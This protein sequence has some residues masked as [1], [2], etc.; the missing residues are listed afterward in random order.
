M[1]SFGLSLLLLKIDIF[2]KTFFTLFLFAL[3][4]RSFACPDFAGLYQPYE[5]FQREII[6]TGCES[7]TI[8]DTFGSIKK[9]RYYPLDGTF[10][11][12]AW[13]S[14]SHA[15]ALDSIEYTLIFDVG[16][17]CAGRYHLTNENNLVDSYRCQS[18][19]EPNPEIAEN[20]Y[21]RINPS[22]DFIAGMKS[23]WL[24]HTL[25]KAEDFY[26]F[27]HQSV[28]GPG[29]LMPDRNQARRN[30]DE[31][32]ALIQPWPRSEPVCE[33]LSNTPGLS[34]LH[35]ANIVRSTGGTA[36]P[37]WPATRERILDAMEH[38]VAVAFTAGSTAGI[39]KMKTRFIQVRNILQQSN[40][41]H[42]IRISYD[43]EYL[44]NKF[45]PM[46]FPAIHHSAIFNENYHPSYRVINS[47][48][49]PTPE[50]H[51]F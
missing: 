32:A 15:W 18:A 19:E 26:K 5:G 8:I 46:G 1:R 38:G 31:E 43:L 7:L 25:M 27:I 51:R 36:S 30:L 2:M 14:H 6:Q 29:H 40:E 49:C 34:R 21:F 24:S 37:D 39:A 4:L 41:A 3:S 17:Y 45:E 48:F 35:L 22:D 11:E 44:E 50:N 33:N 16:A 9:T 10:V 47:R 13:G 20:I 23:H 28:F 12:E 42:A